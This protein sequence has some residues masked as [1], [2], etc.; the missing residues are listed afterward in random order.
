MSTNNNGQVKLKRS[1]NP[2]AVW[3]LAFGCIIGWGS[4][5]N[6]GLKFLPTAG[7]L[8]TAIAMLLG[9]GIMVIIACSYNYL[10][11]RYPV[12][13]GE[14]AYTMAIFGPKHAFICGWFLVLA[15][16]TNVPMNATTLGYMT[17]F[18]FEGWLQGQHLWTVAGF[19]V[20]LGE[21][22][23]SVAA[24][25]L[26]TVF[27]IRGVKVA[28]V[29]Q[30]IFA[31]SLAVSVVVVAIAALCS[32]YTH[33][34]DLLPLFKP[35]AQSTGEAVSGVVAILALAPW[36]YVGFD[37]I[38]QSCEEFNFSQKKVFRIML[39]AIAFG[40]FVYI[41]NTL[42]AAT[43]LTE[44]YT[45]AIAN[46]EI[47]WLLGYAVKNMLGWPGLVILGIA[48]S[49]AILTG[50]LGFL[51]ATS[52]LMYSMANSGYLPAFFGHLNPKTQ[53]PVK[54]LLFCMAVSLVG[55]LFGRVALGWFV[56]MS[57]IGA[58]IGFAYTCFAAR[59]TVK[60]RRDVPHWKRTAVLALVGGC[61]SLLFIVMFLPGLPAALTVEGFIMLGVWILFGVIFYFTR[62]KKNFAV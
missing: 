52:R 26:L 18:L 34:E 5:F 36:A 47:S 38:P 11:P 42:V 39:V 2:F 56:D 59:V 45:E 33:W 6:P 29:V 13:G 10:I 3:A 51:T 54:A 14:F 30:S 62:S 40:A 17:R 28:G 20:Y 53:T 12:A 24:I 25:L 43:A 35:T 57:A 46:P 41:S 23:L 1:L 37:T 50:L 58:A 27:S 48:L 21:V 55:P 44:N 7:P 60:E 8:G 31:I 19:D 61:I 32:P 22:L 4:F 16:L 15:Y 9:A 49:C